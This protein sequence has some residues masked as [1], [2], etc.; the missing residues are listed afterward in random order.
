MQV[1]FNAIVETKSLV[2]CLTFHTVILLL[3]FLT[4]LSGTQIFFSYAIALGA[5]IALGS[6]NNFYNNCYKVGPDEVEA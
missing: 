6:Y 1:I 5:M 3:T 4:L 2:L